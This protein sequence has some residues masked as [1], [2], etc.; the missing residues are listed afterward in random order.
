MAD[1]LRMI[2]AAAPAGFHEQA[3]AQTADDA[4]DTA[5]FPR[6]FMWWMPEVPEA[7]ARLRVV[8]R[9]PTLPAEEITRQI[10]RASLPTPAPQSRTMLRVRP[11]EAKEPIARR[12]VSFL[13]RLG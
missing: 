12:V 8:R 9:A 11:A 10:P 3:S 5:V 7:S 6:D 4:E 1:T 13:Q 2:R